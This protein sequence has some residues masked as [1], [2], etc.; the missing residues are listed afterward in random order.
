MP[1]AT[2]EDVIDRW[3]GPGTP[4]DEEL[5]QRW[6]DDAAVIIRAEVPD[7]EERLEDEEVAPDLATIVFVQSRM[8]T[9]CLRNPRGVRQE[10]VGPYNTTYAGDNPGSPWL[11]DEERS[12]LLGEPVRPRQRAFIVDTTPP[13]AL[14]SLPPDPWG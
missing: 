1:W 7:I 8:V 10:G 9:R 14:S 12:L 13:G 5:I 4:G 3:V 2:P 11:T 6:L